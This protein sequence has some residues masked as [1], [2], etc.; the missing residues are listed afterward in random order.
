MLVDGFGQR[1]WILT[2][3]LKPHLG[4]ATSAIDP[5]PNGAC[6]MKS[7]LTQKSPAPYEERGACWL[8]KPCQ[9]LLAPIQ[10][11]VDC[12]CELGDVVWLN[13]GEHT[14]SQ[15]VAPQLAIRLDIHDAV[16]SQGL[17]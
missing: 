13:R 4:I 10:K 12:L 15:L 1:I 5:H 3:Y 17:G 11:V 6:V 14:N 2:V 16:R 9:L 7:T 8:E